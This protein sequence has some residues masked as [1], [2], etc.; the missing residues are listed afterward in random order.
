MIESASPSGRNLLTGL[1]TGV[2]HTVRSAAFKDSAVLLVGNSIAAGLAFLGA[3]IISRAL[4]PTNF[5]IIS[6]AAAVTAVITGLTDFGIGTGVVRFAARDLET[7]RSKAIALLVAAL[8]VEIA[9][10]ALILVSG[11]LLA[12]P[13]AMLLGGG[14]TL[15]LPLLLAFLAGFG[16]SVGAYNNTVLQVYLKFTRLAALITLYGIAKIAA[17]L[18]LWAGGWLSIESVLIVYAIL[19]LGN[20][21][22]GFLLIPCES[23]GGWIAPGQRV[24]LIELFHF[25]KWIMLSFIATSLTSRLDI[26]M[27]SHYRGAESVGLYAAAFQLATVFPLIIGAVS[28]S[29]LPRASR[30][31]EPAQLRQFVK[32]TLAMSGLVVVIVLPIPFLSPQL[33]ALV[34]G[35]RYIAAIPTFQVLFVAFLFAILINPVSTTLYA[36]D[37]AWIITLINWVQLALTFSLNMILVPAYGSVGAAT[38]FLLSTILAF[39]VVGLVIW[40]L[41]YQ[42]QHPSLGVGYD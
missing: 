1:W 37:R 19:A 35:S 26:F 22:V 29:L 17:I 42:V 6:T 28:T 39:L 18:V 7:D 9:L 10:G 16:L 40:K 30:L 14:E 2:A 24:A 32:R 33:I 5:G 12:R 4:G 41:V 23:W 15:V 25:S 3:V 34:F 13:L 27:L 36:L 21:G 38:T 31:T 11:V 8:K 20:L